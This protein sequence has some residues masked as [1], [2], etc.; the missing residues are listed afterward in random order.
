MQTSKQTSK[1]RKKT[2]TK[3]NRNLETI[4]RGM[5]IVPDTVRTKLRFWKA[6]A[7]NLSAINYSGVR[8]R[9]S[10]AFEPDPLTSDQPRGFTEWSNFYSS[11][12]VSGSQCKLEVINPSNVTP[13]Q[14]CLLPVNLDPGASPSSGAV[15][16]SI[17]QPFARRKMVSLVGGPLTTINHS[18]TTEKLFGNP[19]TK[20]DE[21]FTALV[22]GVPVNNWYWFV[23]FYSLAVI[24]G[25]IVAHI[26]IDI[27][28][29]FYDRKR[30]N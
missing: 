8:F 6:F 30:L 9:P 23:T 1:Q 5:T 2:V 15:T 14:A 28:V 29:T 7:V 12:K 22:T 25:G 3:N 11:Y 27:D 21:N 17:E 20:Y 4:P 18:M 16:G 13:V 19:M 26:F 24:P 10:A